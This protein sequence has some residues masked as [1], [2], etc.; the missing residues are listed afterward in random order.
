MTE[1]E[2][3]NNNKIIAEFMGVKPCR[4]HPDKQCF[5]KIK[6]NNN[7]SLQYFHLLK[8]HKSWDWLIPVIDKIYS[9]DDYVKYKDS[10]GQFSDGVFINIKFISSTYNNVVDYIKW[11]NDN[12]KNKII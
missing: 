6:D 9:S 10:L 3:L 11:Y 8:Y 1:Q 12:K 4:T 2:I 5:L 7:P